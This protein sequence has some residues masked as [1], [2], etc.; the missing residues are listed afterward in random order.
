MSRLSPTVVDA[1]MDGL[2][3]RSHEA[4]CQRQFD[5]AD[6]RFEQDRTAENRQAR[7]EAMTNLGRAQ[8][9]LARPD[10]HQP[11]LHGFILRE[12]QPTVP[13]PPSRPAPRPIH[14][15]R[16][17]GAAHRPAARRAATR[18]GPPDD[19]SDDSEPGGAGPELTAAGAP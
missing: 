4:G 17:R 1:A 2:D 12:H 9:D 5:D 11:D 18:A 6:A 10:Y 16:S 8:N 3:A 19:E 15:P 14:A 13:A 7:A